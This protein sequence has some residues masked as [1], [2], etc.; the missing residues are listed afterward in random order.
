MTP[1]ASRGPLQAAQAGDAPILLFLEAS[2]GHGGGRTLSQEI[3]QS[4]SMYAFL[5]DRLALAVG[6]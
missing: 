1:T 5:A 3:D 4:A 2:S 6:R